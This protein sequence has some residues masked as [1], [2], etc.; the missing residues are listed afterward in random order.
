MFT[1][2]QNFKMTPLNIGI[3]VALVIV[4][5]FILYK[6]YKYFTNK[7]E[8]FAFSDDAV[9]RLIY[10]DWCG[11]CTVTKPE[12]DKLGDVYT[13]NS[14]KNV[15]IEKLNGDRQ[16]NLVDKLNID[17]N[18]YPTIVLTVNGMTKKYHGERTFEAFE[19]YLNAN[20]V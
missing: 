6:V 12:F 13:T 5:G 10:V 9:F 18:G 4:V 19:Q 1:F 7:D 2:L 20:V 17:V 11:H 15:V 8:S 3:A 14:G 16:R